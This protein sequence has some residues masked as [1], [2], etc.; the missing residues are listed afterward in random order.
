MIQKDNILQE[1][2]ELESSLANKA[3]ENCYTVPA[4]YFEDL[5]GQVLARIKAE[6]AVS[7]DEELS[8]LAP[9]LSHISRN[10]PLI[11]PTGYFEGLEKRMIEAVRDNSHQSAQEELE[12]LSPLLGGLKKEMPFGVPEGYF[13]TISA[14]PLSADKKP[15]AKVVSLINKKLVRYAAAAAVVLV[16]GTIAIFSLN[17]PSASEKEIFAKMSREVNKMNENE[18]DNLVDFLNAGLNGEETAQ[19]GG[20]KTNDFRK[21]LED[22]PE[23]ELNDFRKQNEDLVDFLLVSE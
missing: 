3:A 12:S 18:K 15:A 13:D 22:V 23:E 2:K 4:G 11:V 9:G 21:Y 10:M 19:A 20:D 5:A 1:L 8:Y 7:V 16:A 17:R 14:Q 6:Q